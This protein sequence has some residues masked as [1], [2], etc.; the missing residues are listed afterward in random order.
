M[1]K[2]ALKPEPAWNP[3]A[4]CPDC[5]VSRSGVAGRVRQPNRC[6]LVSPDQLS[7]Q[8]VGTAADPVSGLTD[9]VLL[10][11]YEAVIYCRRFAFLQ[12]FIYKF[13]LALRGA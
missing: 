11:S 3:C 1:P 10:K 8:V 6:R 7:G 13:G 12:P 5:R 2:K 4:L 9:P